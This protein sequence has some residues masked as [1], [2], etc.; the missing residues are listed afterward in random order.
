MGNKSLLIVSI[1]EKFQEIC[2]NKLYFVGGVVRDML[3]GYNTRDIDICG[4]DDTL[5][6]YDEMKSWLLNVG[7]K[8]TI[9]YS[10]FNT[11]N[12]D[13]NTFHITFAAFRNEF[14]STGSGL[15]SQIEVSDRQTDMLRRDFTI[16]TGYLEVTNESI[17]LMTL[18]LDDQLENISFDDKITFA[19][20]LFFEDLHE[21]TIRLLKTY[22][23]IEDPS[24]IYRA[25]RYEVRYDF[26]LD[27]DL[28]LALNQALENKV[29]QKMSTKRRQTELFRLISEMN[30]QKNI[31]ICI[32]RKIYLG[33]SL[34]DTVD[35]YQ[36]KRYLELIHH[37]LQSFKKN[38]DLCQRFYFKASF[39]IILCLYENPNLDWAGYNKQLMGSIDDYNAIKASLH[40]IEF[41]DIKK[42]AYAVYK[43]LY[44]KNVEAIIASLVFVKN[45]MLP[46]SDVYE[47]CVF[48]YLTNWSNIEK[49]K[50]EELKRYSIDQGPIYGKIIEL[51]H[52]NQIEM[53]L[54]GKILS[55]TDRDRL[56]RG[57]INHEY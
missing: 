34:I 6:V 56:I 22:A 4:S 27:D 14:Y 54:E 31:E 18:Y 1:I 47:R 19:H 41:R 8:L 35:E 20:P 55:K 29:L 9:G 43:I 26:I 51:I 57:F 45:E 46:G 42:C 13:G 17:H 33:E 50:G 52:K 40:H 39:Y 49:I 28:S 5:M 3:L 23:F 2:Q 7:E 25:I 48:L 30:W 15:P 16:N 53:S 38:K 24:R 44:N 36:L 12:I 37:T 10:Q 32:K 21:G 11:I